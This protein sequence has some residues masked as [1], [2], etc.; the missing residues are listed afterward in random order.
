[1]ESGS[2]SATYVI[3]P[4][5]IYM[6]YLLF[7]KIGRKGKFSYFKVAAEQ[8]L[9]SSLQCAEQSLL[10]IYT[11]MYICTNIHEGHHV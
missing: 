3:F 9:H 1:M 11:Y 10:N 5:Y 2:E 7:L 4:P 8:S 6:V